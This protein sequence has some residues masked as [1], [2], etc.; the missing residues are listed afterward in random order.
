MQDRQFLQGLDQQKAQ[1]AQQG[2]QF[3]ETQANQIK[4]FDADL[5]QKAQQFGLNQQQQTALANLD[6]DTKLQMATIEAAFKGDIQNS[7]NISNA[8]GSM[9]TQIGN[10]QNNPDLEPA[11]KTT[12]INNTIGAFKGFATF[13]NKA[14]GVDVSA[15]LNFTAG[16]VPA[17]AG[18]PSGGQGAARGAASNGDDIVA[19]NWV[20]GR[21]GA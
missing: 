9:M 11:A 1:L 6:K 2:K 5:S 14:A 3:G 19:D 10:V 20:E 7:A 18:K 15:L 4:M 13:W 17:G 16:D 21:Y 12:L 8:W